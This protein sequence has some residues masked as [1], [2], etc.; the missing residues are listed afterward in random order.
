MKILKLTVN[1]FTDGLE[2]VVEVVHWEH[3]GIKSSTKLKPPKK[4]FKPIADL[5]ESQI[6]S[7]V[8]AQDAKKIEKFLKNKRMASTFAF[9]E[10]PELSEEAE[11]AKKDYWVEWA[12][13]RLA[14][15]VLLD[16]QAE[17]REMQPTGEQTLNEETG[18]MEDVLQEVVVKRE[19]EPVEE[20]VEQ[21]MY[22]DD[23]EVEPTVES[24]RNPLVVDDE[25]ERQKALDILETYNDR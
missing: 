13:N 21:M 18:E 16:G 5:E 1:E 23:P 20:F 24:V 19:I 9:G 25:A 7:W 6:I 4:I 17:V 14:Q 2:Q 8:W 3:K 12:N 10:T 15:Y 22:S 11:Q